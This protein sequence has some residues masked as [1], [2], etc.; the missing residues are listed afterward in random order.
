MSSDRGTVT[1][2]VPSVTYGPKR[3][4]LITIG[5]FVSG[6][7]PS[8]RNGAAAAR[9]WPRRSFG[10]AKISFARSNVTVKISS[11]DPNDR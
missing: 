11:S 6:S 10:C 3:P 2:V 4:S 7:S 5:F 1:L 8:S 9:I